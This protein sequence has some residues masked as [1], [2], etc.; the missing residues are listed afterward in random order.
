MKQELSEKLFKAYPKI[1]PNAV[2]KDEQ[3]ISEY[4]LFSFQVEDG[5]YDIIENLCYTIQN[6]I[7]SRETYLFHKK[8]SGG[9]V[10][11]SDYIPQVVAVQVKEKFGGLRFYVS[12]G[13][14]FCRGAIFMA[15]A[16]S[17]HTCELCS[18]KGELRKGGWVRTLCDQHEEER[19]AGK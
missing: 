7:D 4:E 19:K 8:N 17:H 3:H 9:E 1:F 5:W 14:E 16:L 10:K 11:D 18:S 6:H 12:G 15:E 2:S 13:D